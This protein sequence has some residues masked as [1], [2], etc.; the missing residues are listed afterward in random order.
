M[1]V[2]TFFRSTMI[3][4]IHHLIIKHLENDSRRSNAEPYFTSEN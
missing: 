4:I 3:I 1:E 2:V